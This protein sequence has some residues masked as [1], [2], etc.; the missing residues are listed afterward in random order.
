MWDEAWQLQGVE[1]LAGLDR[2]RH[3][4]V[5]DAAAGCRID[6]GSLG[7]FADCHLDHALGDSGCGGRPGD[8]EFESG[9]GGFAEVEEPGAVGLG[10]DANGRIRMEGDGRAVLESPD[11]LA[12]VV[13]QL[14]PTAFAG[15]LFVSAL[16]FAGVE[17]LRLAGGGGIAILVP[18]ADTPPIRRVR[19]KRLA[20]V[21]HVDRLRRSDLAGVPHVAGFLSQQRGRGGHENPVCALPVAC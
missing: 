19:R 10:L 2:E 3:L 15:P 1:A 18:G 13:G 11:L 6:G 16:E 20:A 12:G 4:A 14:D 7:F 17:A 9:E 8:G 21:E 5:N